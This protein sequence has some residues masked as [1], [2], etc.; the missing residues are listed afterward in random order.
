M[1]S[2]ATSP[3]RAPASIDMLHTVIRP[4]IDS[5]RMAEPR[6]SMTW[7]MPPPVPMR[8]MMARITS[9]AVTSGG[10]SPS[11]STAIHFGPG[12]GER[13]GG[14]HVLD[15]G[16]ADAEGQRAER[17]V[18]RGVGVAAD[19]GHARQGA[20]LLGSDDVDD[21][22]AGV[23]H[24]VERDAELGRRWPACTSTWRAEIGIGDRLV[25]VG[26]RD[27]VVLGGDGEVRPAHAC[28]RPGAG[29]R[30]PAGWSPRGRGGGRCRA[31]P[32]RP[33][34]GARRGGPTPSGAG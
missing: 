25:D 27:V 33:A 22:L 18:G 14:Q 11:T 20:T 16:G 21:A 29:R 24:R 7:P 26:R 1:S 28:G 17:A 12:L 34:P 4:S 15:L 31:G 23:A 3:A 30:R 6:Y 19:D 9:L 5:E 10:S 8:P 2:G 13:L 32:A